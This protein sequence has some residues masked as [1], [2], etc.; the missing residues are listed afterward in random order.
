MIY[1]LTNSAIKI[2]IATAPPTYRQEVIDGKM[3]VGESAYVSVFQ[4]VGACVY[5]YNGGD[6]VSATFPHVREG[7]R[8]GGDSLLNHEMGKY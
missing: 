8:E 1:S 3:C 4:G 2:T 5:M 7:G 6:S